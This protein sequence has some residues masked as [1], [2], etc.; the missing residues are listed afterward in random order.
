[1][2][3]VQR[4]SNSEQYFSLFY[5]DV[6]GH[7]QVRHRKA[8]KRRKTGRNIYWSAKETASEGPIPPP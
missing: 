5:N 7:F 8:E 3:K 4:P 6:Q 1:M 2:E